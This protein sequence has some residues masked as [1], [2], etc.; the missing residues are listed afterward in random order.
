MR[1][2]VALGEQDTRYMTTL[3]AFLERK[4]GEQVEIKGFSTPELLKEFLENNRADIVLLD[5]KFGMTPEEIPGEPNVAWL[6]DDNDRTGIDGVQAA[7]KF[8]KPELIYQDILA[9]YEE[10]QSGKGY[11]KKKCD[12]LLFQS[13]SGGVGTSTMAAAAAVHF[14]GA[15]EKVL[16][17]NLETTGNSANFF[18]GTGNGSFDDVIDAV[19]NDELDLSLTMENSVRCSNNGVYYFTPCRMATSMLELTDENIMEILTILKTAKAYEKVIVD[20]GFSLSERCLKIMDYADKIVIVNDGT[21]VA[22]AKAIRTVRSLEVLEKQKQIS[23]FDHMVL[24]Y[25][26]FSSSKSSNEISAISIPV[27]GKIPPI[28]HASVQEIMQIMLTKPEIFEAI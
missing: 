6:V 21:D 5:E 10:K 15:G 4:Y 18:R 27:A 20:M 8:R 23:I 26:K 3:L 24:V 9:L 12:I 28:K 7:G 17:L 19:R 1:I 13:F 14:A 25:N 2:Q 11:K 16:Y 22:N